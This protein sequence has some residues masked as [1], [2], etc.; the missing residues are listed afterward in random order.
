MTSYAKPTGDELDTLKKEAETAR[1]RISTAKGDI[2]FSFYAHEAPQH[3]A[4][5]MKL[6]RAGFYDG[7]T[8]HRVEPGFVIQGGDPDGNG[9][10]GPGYNLDAEFSSLPHVKGDGLRWRV[11]LIRI[12]PVRSFIYA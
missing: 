4:A 5:F 12:Q 8:F 6:A 7:L 3:A 11:A 1:A 10:G 9:T 2:V